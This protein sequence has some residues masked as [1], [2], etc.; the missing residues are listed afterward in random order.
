MKPR[1]RPTL[2]RRLL[3]VLATL[4]VTAG[5]V[6]AN[7]PMVAAG[8]EALHTF[9]INR[10]S[11]KERYGHWSRLPVPR[12]FRV[13]AIHAALLHTG[14]VLIIA[15]SG[16]D[17]EEFEAK[18]FRTVLYDPATDEFS[19]VHTPTDVFCAGHTFLP[20]GKLLVAGGTRSYEVLESEVERAAGVMK[21]K[22]ESPDGGPR[23]LPKGTRL[24]SASGRQYRTRSRVQVPA[25]RKTV[26]GPHVTVLAG[27]AEVWVDAVD[28]GDG[29]VVKA[30]AQYSVAGLTGADARNLYGVA[31]KITREKQEY[32][33]DRTSYEFDP[34]TERYVRTGSLTDARWYPTLVGLPGGDVLAVSGLDQ[35]GRVLPGRNE[36]YLYA[37]HRWVAAPQWKRYFPTYP[38][39]HLMADGRIF[40]SGS[41]AGYGSDTEGRTPGVWDLR[42]NSFQP[43]PGLRDPRLTETSS[44]VLLPPA[45][46][47]KVMIFGGGGVGESPVSTARTAVADLTAARPEYRPGPDLPKPA[48]YLSTVLM[49]DDTVFT[50]GGSSG[51]RGGPYRGEPRSDLHNAQFYDARRDTFRTAAESAVGRNYHAEAILLPD[52]RVITLGSDPLYDESGKNAGTFEQRIEIYS[53]PYLFRGARPAITDGPAEVSRGGT[54]RFTTPDAGRITAARLI[55]PSAVTHVTDT[56]QRSVSLTVRPAAGAVDVVV[57]HGAGLVPSGWYM[58]FVT[59]DRGVPSA[60]RWVRVR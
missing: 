21:L 37:R 27:E 24:V 25:A 58:L 5:V 55:R 59:D 18:S 26:H 3:S 4:L 43:V 48:R 29:P 60:G 40:Y 10:Q 38:G 22:N 20:D 52:G 39:L 53:P 11:Y 7:R 12:D 47:Q 56:D 44:S 31:E 17:R 30:P 6:V 36:R 13:N 45:Q 1:T 19:E 16:N 23:V 9:Q 50:T 49:P 42:R 34:V 51:Y 57:P 46:D 32:G 28:K 54:A 15:G 2:A 14:K 35:F 33:G 41:N 8:A